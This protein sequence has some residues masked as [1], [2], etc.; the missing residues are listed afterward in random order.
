[1]FNNQPAAGN[2]RTTRRR[3]SDQPANPL[4]EYSGITAGAPSFSYGSPNNARYNAPRLSDYNVPIHDVLDRA[5]QKTEA[6]LRGVEEGELVNGVAMDRMKSFL[7]VAADAMLDPH[8]PEQDDVRREEEEEV[9]IPRRSPRKHRQSSVQLHEPRRRLRSDKDSESV[10]SQ[11]LGEG[12]SKPAPRTRKGRSASPVK[13]HP[14]LQPAATAP[15]KGKERARS[16]S[17]VPDSNSNS[18]IEPE[19]SASARVRMVEATEGAEREAR[20]LGMSPEETAVHITRAQRKARYHG[21][22][23]RETRKETRF[24]DDVESYVYQ[25]QSSEVEQAEDDE[26]EDE[27][28]DHDE[29]EEEEEEEEDLYAR[30]EERPGVFNS[31]KNFLMFCWIVS[32]SLIRQLLEAIARLIGW[33]LRGTLVTPLRFIRRQ[34]RN[35]VWKWLMVIPVAY[36]LYRMRSLPAQLAIGLTNEIPF[37]LRTAGGAPSY[38]APTIPPENTDELVSRLMSLERRLAD[39]ASVNDDLVKNNNHLNDFTKEVG[40]KQKGMDGSIGSLGDEIQ[41]LV[42]SAKDLGKDAKDMKDQV[43]DMRDTVSRMQTALTSFEVQ[44]EQNTGRF[45]DIDGKFATK[46]KEVRELRSTIGDV[47]SDLRE[48]HKEVKAYA[49]S[50]YISK[51]ALETI[52]KYLPAHVAVRTNPK[53]G[54]VDVAPEF[55]AQLKSAF[56]EREDVGRIV[57]KAVNEARIEGSSQKPVV[58]QPNWDDFLRENREA[59][60]GIA[61][62]QGND[63]W[64]RKE[65]AGAVISRSAFLDLLR[66]RIGD[67][68]EDIE[69][70][71]KDLKF[72][73]EKYTDDEVKT[74]ISSIKGRQGTPQSLNLTD[75]A[76]DSIIASALQRYASESVGRAD[77]AAYAAGA[78]VNPFLTSKTYVMKPRSFFGRLLPFS[79]V[80]SNPPAIA[81]HPDN[82]VGMCWPF[83]GQQGQMG[84]RLSARVVPT[85]ITI[86]HVQVE[87]AQDITSAPKEIEVWA[88]VEDDDLRE[89][90]GAAALSV[91]PRQKGDLPSVGVDFV[92][93]AKFTYDVYEEQ[94]IQTFPI[95]DVIKDAAVPVEQIVIRVLSNWGN[96]D[97]TCLYRVRIHGETQP[98]ARS[99]EED[100]DNDRLI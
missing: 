81:L 82:S 4:P 42:A 24:N 52:E 63:L 34:L 30:D 83:A 80:E 85:E 25:Q 10:H 76:L 32:W 6:R 90:V 100:M 9:H 54:K 70:I 3:I 88:F 35:G 77:Y 96:V 60:E 13:P 61:R 15:R 19:D 50:E 95:A 62:Q 12:P 99:T 36:G 59:I 45:K 8:S 89:Q 23:P 21:I 20:E 67:L 69:R 57:Q 87:V 66:E 65:D 53:T 26:D 58:I 29:E 31:I 74:A 38:T 68:G 1:M 48:L 44:L 11:G 27:D 2:R 41:K 71:L 39:F 55:W 18:E 7:G 17:T 22:P 72:S 73:L 46:D 75:L 64:E 56:A 98:N 49:N 92:K 93:I 37:S 5:I 84:I 28:E 97:Y 91:I 47:K 40:S 33:A 16:A 14:R 86:E 78:R 79:G 43:Q 51:H 94:A